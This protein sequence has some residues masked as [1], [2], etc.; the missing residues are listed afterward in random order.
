MAYHISERNP[1]NLEEIQRNVV[2]MEANF[3]IEKSKIKTKKIVTI[4]EET[5]TSSEGKL[6][7]LIKT[8]EKMMDKISIIDRQ[9]EPSIRN[10][11]FRGQNQQ[12]QYRIKEREQRG[13]DPQIQ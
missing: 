3:I 6:D 1:S 11:N 7:T 4:K 13:Q 2:S 10:P 12:P 8:L 5:S 9:A